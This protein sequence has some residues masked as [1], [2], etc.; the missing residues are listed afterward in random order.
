MIPST[1][2][3]RTSEISVE[4]LEQYIKEIWPETKRS[5]ITVSYKKINDLYL[6]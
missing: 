6:L 2:P 4:G 5:D 1:L 3:I